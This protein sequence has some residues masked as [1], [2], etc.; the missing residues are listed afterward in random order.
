M[1]FSVHFQNRHD[2]DFSYGLVFEPAPHWYR[3]ADL[4]ARA[5]A[6]GQRYGYGGVARLLDAD[7]LR[8]DGLEVKPNAVV[9]VHEYGPG[10]GE[11]LVMLQEDLQN[12]GFSVQ[13]FYVTKD[14]AKRAG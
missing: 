4:V 1:H 11:D 14:A 12:E 9:L 3:G 8:F 2:R 5:N 10:T 6:Q 13:T 7:V